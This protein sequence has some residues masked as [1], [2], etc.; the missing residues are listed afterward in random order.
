MGTHDLI[1]I[2]KGTRLQAVVTA[3][4]YTDIWTAV[5]NMSVPVAEW[6]GTFLR[7][8]NNGLVER[9]TNDGELYHVMVICSARNPV[10]E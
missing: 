9:I 1:G 3:H 8:H 6:E 4:M 10:H 7:V 2:P 5:K